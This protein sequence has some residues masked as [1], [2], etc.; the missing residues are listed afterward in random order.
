M[1]R[2]RWS[3]IPVIG[4]LSWSL[5]SG[6]IL[7]SDDFSDPGTTNLKWVTPFSTIARTCANGVYTITNSDA[8]AGYVTNTL[9]PKP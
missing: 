2:M 9:T 7:F 3:I 8:D 5:A 4:C 1:T 6:A